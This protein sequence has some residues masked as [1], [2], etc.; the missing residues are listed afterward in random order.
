M[1]GATGSVWNWW[2]F[3]KMIFN[4][5]GSCYS[6]SGSGLLLFAALQFGPRTG[7]FLA[8]T[9]KNPVWARVIICWDSKPEQLVV[10]STTKEGSH[11]SHIPLPTATLES[12]VFFSVSASLH[13]VSW[14]FI[15]YLGIKRAILYNVQK[16]M[17]FSAGTHVFFGNFTVYIWEGMVRL[18]LLLTLGV[19][20]GHENVI[21]LM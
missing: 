15:S 17:A 14:W 18:L 20:R 6:I 2:R 3:G 10:S 1:S 12:R 21:T 9:W 19:L 16:N 7:Q 4:T 8:K 13:S 11:H 5:L